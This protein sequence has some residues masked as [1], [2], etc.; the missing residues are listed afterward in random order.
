MKYSFI[1]AFAFYIISMILDNA[2]SAVGIKSGVAVE[3]NTWI[4]GLF[5]TDKE[6]A[7][8]YVIYGSLEALLLSATAIVSLVHP[9]FYL[10]LWLS[11]GAWIGMGIKHLQGFSEWRKLGTKL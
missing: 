5:G 10:G 6:T 8:Q 11:G 7:W 1:T 2:I 3:G 4:N 9:A